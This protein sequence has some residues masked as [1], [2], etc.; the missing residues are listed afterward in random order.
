VVFAASATTRIELR[1]GV[2]PRSVGATQGCDVAGF[3]A[4]FGLTALPQF[5]QR[6]WRTAEWIRRWMRICALMDAVPFE[7][8]KTLRTTDATAGP[9]DADAADLTRTPFERIR[10]GPKAG[11]PSATS[12]AA[13]GNGIGNGAGIAL[14]PRGAP[15][16]ARHALLPPPPQV[17]PA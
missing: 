13:T 9:I 8:M 17:P 10:V 1:A 5:S 3:F 15:R 7:E 16:G 14:I 12:A 6:T 2:P 4:S 11:S